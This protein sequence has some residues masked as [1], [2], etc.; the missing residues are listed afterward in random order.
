MSLTEVQPIRKPIERNILNILE[1]MIQAIPNEGEEHFKCDLERQLEKAAYIAPENMYTVW[2]NVQCIITDRFK[3]YRDTSTL[4]QW[5][6]LLIAIW[7]DKK[8]S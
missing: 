5:S 3:E 2:Q 8:H 4:P 6:R 1:S 7:T